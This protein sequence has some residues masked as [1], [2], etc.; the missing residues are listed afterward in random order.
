MLLPRC[1][2]RFTLRPLAQCS[3]LLVR[4]RVLDGKANQFAGSIGVYS[5]LYRGLRRGN[6]N[7]GAFLSWR[8]FPNGRLEGGTRL[9]WHDIHEIIDRLFAF[10]LETCSRFVCCV[11]GGENHPMHLSPR[12]CLTDFSYI[13][14]GGEVMGDIIMTDRVFS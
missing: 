6:C 9:T 14:C 3:A 11:H 1:R 2:H 5:T 12:R 4:N 7:F 13:T 8:R 10:S